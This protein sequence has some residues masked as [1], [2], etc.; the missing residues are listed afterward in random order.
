[1]LP[2]PILTQSSIDYRLT[3]CNTKNVTV[4]IRPVFETS[5]L[6]Q[7]I[8]TS[9]KKWVLDLQIVLDKEIM[10]IRQA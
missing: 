7:H 8:G 9:L 10:L 4:A 2:C 3:P 1:M 6:Q 5:L